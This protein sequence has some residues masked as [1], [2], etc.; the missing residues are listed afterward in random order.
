M[1]KARVVA[2]SG[3]VSY[4]LHTLG[5][6]AFQDLC[7]TIL[8]EVL[9]QTFQ[10]FS[11]GKDGGRDGAFQ[12]AWKTQDGIDLKGSFTAQCKF[13]TSKDSSLSLSILTDDIRKAYSLSQVG[14]SDNYILMTNYKVT[15]STDEKVKKAFAAVGI[16]NCLLFGHEKISQF[17]TESPRL[18]RL[19]PRV[20]G[21]GDLS[22]ILDERSYAQA[23]QLL[24]SLQDDLA[25]FVP[26]EAYRKSA[27]ALS[28]HGFVLLLGE[29]ASGKSIIAATLALSAADEWQC[30]TLKVDTAASFKD[31]WNPHDPRQFFWVDDAFGTTQ[32]QAELVQEWN[33]KFPELHAAIKK[34]ARVAFTSRDY[35]YRKAKHDLKN[36][37]FPLLRESQVI[38]N[39]QDLSGTEKQEILYNHIKR[40]DQPKAF[41]KTVKPF[42]EDI[43]SNQHFQPEIARRLGT[44]TFTKKLGLSSPEL[45]SFVEKPE[46]FL[47]SVIEGLGEEE[48]SALALIFMHGGMLESPIALSVQ[49]MEAITRIG[50]TENGVGKAMI[51]MRDS[52]V[53]LEHGSDGKAWVFKHPTIGDAF[54][55]L[56]AKNDE[57]LDIYLQGTKTDK[58]V[59]EVVCGKIALEG[60]KVIIPSSRYNMI[61]S[62]LDGIPRNSEGKR[63]VDL[64]LTHR[65]ARDF[66][67]VYLQ[68]HQDLFDRISCPG[69]Y[70][71]A[72]SESKLLLRLDKEKLLPAEHRSRFV[73]RIKELAVE[74]PDAGFL[75][76][77]GMRTFLTNEEVSEILSAVREELVPQLDDVIDNWRDNYQSNDDPDTYFD[78]LVDALKAYKSELEQYETIAGQLEAALEQ[79][80][81][82]IDELRVARE[83][84][85]DEW[86][87]YSFP[88]TAANTDNKSV[89]SIF[90]DLD[91]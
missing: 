32:Y 30:T 42:L 76:I 36:S 38:I 85:E 37:A 12:G 34:G 51:S 43:A 72:V 82:I 3:F 7:G 70:L 90:D 27:K 54:A 41:K 84:P 68:S 10:T 33:R 11:P 55:G 77:K 45:R 14:L 8:S 23:E 19:V 89:R 91:E 67:K 35:I 81:T 53:K 9:G 62:R 47:L 83:G 87:D 64:F 4:E 1:S 29:P 26:T 40:G 59:H 15:G 46:E 39:V 5:W 88:S 65:C 28:R 63:M 52:L 50:G 66:L 13:T 16:Q 44:Q 71:Y 17:I 60:A 48:Q 25:K 2:Q 86:R 80:D 78:E 75:T 74:T 61:I 24:L 22:Q 21:L 69:S 57:L 73:S 20:Y 56:V 49:D 18:R 6:K 58:L 31:H 79:I